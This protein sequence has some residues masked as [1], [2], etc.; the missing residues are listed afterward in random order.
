MKQ[1]L[2]FPAEGVRPRLARSAVPPCAKMSAGQALVSCAEAPSARIGISSNRVYDT[3]VS[4]AWLAQ[5]MLRMLAVLDDSV[6]G[7]KEVP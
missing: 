1:I 5:A 3:F 7:V 2:N 6:I 4:I